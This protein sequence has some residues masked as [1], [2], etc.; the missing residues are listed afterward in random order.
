[1]IYKLILLLFIAHLIADFILQPHLWSTEKKKAPLTKYHLYHI[2]VVLVLTF[3]LSL[4]PKFWWGASIIVITH[5][6][7]D[8]LKS[9]IELNT[10]KSDKERNY[11]FW[12]QFLHLLVI[13]I[14]STIFSR[15]EEIIFLVDIPIKVLL[16]TS[17]FLLCAKP[18]NIIIKNVFIAFSISIPELKIDAH[19]EAIPEDKGLPN[20]GKLIG[21][22]ERFLVLALI[23]IGQYSAVGLIIAAKSILRFRSTDRN[24]YILVG[25]LLSFGIAGLVGILVTQLV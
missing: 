6:L 7:I 21:I 11:F 19:S 17:A 10:Q 5:F 18:A 1:M 24:E 4:S 15:F 25:T 12:D 8:I 9:Y 3:I 22:M 23:L 20:A 16:I 13:I 14:V 2:A